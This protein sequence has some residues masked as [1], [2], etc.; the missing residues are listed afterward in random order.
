MDT[1]E[2]LDNAIN[3]ALGRDDKVTV[4]CKVVIKEMAHVEQETKTS[5]GQVFQA[6]TAFLIPDVNTTNFS[7]LMNTRFEEDELPNGQE[8]VGILPYPCRG[9][10][11]VAF[12]YSEKDFP[13]TPFHFMVMTE[14]V[15]Q[16]LFNMEGQEI[17]F[18]VMSET[19]E[20][21]KNLEV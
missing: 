21:E 12:N 13:Q 10:V 19:Y 18:S 20:V 6:K 11:R 9:F 15:E 17:P 4:K 1:T 16:M 7:L 14:K 3:K 8:M 2:S 5:Q